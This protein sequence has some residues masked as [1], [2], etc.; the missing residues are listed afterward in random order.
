MSERGLAVDDPRYPVDGQH[1]IPGSLFNVTPRAAELGGRTGSSFKIG[2]T[3]FL[4]VR[5]KSPNVSLGMPKL[6]EA[7][8]PVLDSKDDKTAGKDSHARNIDASSQKSGD[9]RD[10]SLQNIQQNDDRNEPEASSARLSH[11]SKESSKDHSS[12]DSSSE[13]NQVSSSPSPSASLNDE[14]APIVVS[15]LPDDDDFLPNIKLNRRSSGETSV[16][17]NIEPQ[18]AGIAVEL[19]SVK[20]L[21]VRTVDAILINNSESDSEQ[22]LSKSTNSKSNASSQSSRHPDLR[23]SETEKN[24]KSESSIQANKRE[25]EQRKPL[26]IASITEAAYYPIDIPGEKLSWTKFK[27]SDDTKALDESL[28]DLLSG[29]EQTGVV[30]PFDT[31]QQVKLEA[32]ILRD[33]IDSIKESAALRGCRSANDVL[34]GAHRSLSQILQQIDK[35]DEAKETV[36]SEINYLHAAVDEYRRTHD[37]EQSLELLRKRLDESEQIFNYAHNKQRRMRLL[38]EETS[39]ERLIY[40]IRST[41]ERNDRLK[42]RLWE[43]YCIGAGCMRSLA[44]QEECACFEKLKQFK[45]NT[46]GIKET[47]IDWRERLIEAQERQFK[48]SM[49]NHFS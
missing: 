27:M 14:E 23:R 30:R 29:L 37:M 1:H 21:S 31:T 36:R 10:A 33:R 26:A 3:P 20:Q 38:L 43:P 9:S 17:Q 41:R 19:H 5:R 11:S 6:G 22:A 15:K 32:D 4:K 7:G 28:S 47:D 35:E 8:I 40:E 39:I 13:D 18:S 16:I 45:G 12:A 49:H 48:N 46:N 25:D 44:K 34:D 42:T 2:V 24:S